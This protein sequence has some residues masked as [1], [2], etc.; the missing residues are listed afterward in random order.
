MKIG[1]VGSRGVVG[2]ASSYSFR[3]LG[4]DVKEHDI[5]IDSKLKDVLDTAICFICVPTP[6]NLDGSCNTGIVEKVID[7]LMEMGYKGFVVVKS[8]ISPGTIDKIREKYLSLEYKIVFS[9]E[10]LRER[11]AV[12]DA[13]DGQHILIIGTHGD[14][15]FDAVVAAHGH[16]PKRIFRMTPTE[17]EL[18]KYFHNVF[19]A[20]RVVYANAFYEVCQKLDANYTKIKNAIVSQPTHVDYYLDCNDS[21]RGYAGVCL[22]KDAPA[23]EYIAKSLGVPAEIFRV[24]VDDNKLYKPTVPDGMRLE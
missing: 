19:N 1:I 11:H 7:G 10:F 3:K 6:P 21:F 18:S 15:A 13:T 24:I 5:R 4:H 23:L 17:A 2:S 9:P 14:A 22:S 16:Y 20:L 12:H 8:T